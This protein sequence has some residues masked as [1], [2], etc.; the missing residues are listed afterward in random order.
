MIL[1]N[2]GTDLPIVA[3]THECVR[4]EHLRKRNVSKT[5]Y[6]FTEEVNSEEK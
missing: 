5:D 1:L 2:F 6:I 4:G 3:A